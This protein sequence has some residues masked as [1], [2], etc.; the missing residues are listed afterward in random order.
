[1]PPPR[2]GDSWAIWARPSPARARTAW[3][4]A[5]GGSLAVADGGNNRAL[6]YGCGAAILVASPTLTATVSPTR[7]P[8]FTASP[9]RTPSFTA[10]PSD[11]ASPT[12]TVSPTYTW[13]LTPTLT[14][15]LTPSLSAT[16]TFTQ[17]SSYTASPTPSFS[18][19]ASPTPTRT[20]TF[21]V[22]PSVTPYPLAYGK[23]LAWPNPIPRDAGGVN[24]GVP[25]QA[26]AV[27]L[28]IYDR[29][30][31]PVAH[32]LLS[33]GQA[34]LGWVRWDLRNSQGVVVAPGLYLL[35]A[36]GKGQVWMGKVTVR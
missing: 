4:A 21:T 24:L 34:G 8:S 31:Q 17:T 14:F 2:S 23:V 36:Q 33:P 11:T 35:R 20:Q 28:D 25:P 12:F 6:F 26:D 5:A 30:A 7:T 3:S 13:S 9:T 32:L 16:P 29:M 22:I 10:S 18:P 1:M 27:S 15:T 19:T